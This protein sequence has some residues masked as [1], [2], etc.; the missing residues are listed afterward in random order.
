MI[1]L[2]SRLYSPNR[3]TRREKKRNKTVSLYLQNRIQQGENFCHKNVTE[4]SLSLHFSCGAQWS[5]G[6]AWLNGRPQW[7]SGVPG[8][9]AHSSPLI[10]PLGLW[11]AR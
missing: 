3:R 10:V 5:H 11:P 4:R 8:R 6:A 9:E 2:H 1:L 7:P